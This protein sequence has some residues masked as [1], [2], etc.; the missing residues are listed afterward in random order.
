ML[1]DDFPMML[2][3]ESGLSEQYPPV[4]VAFGMFPQVD[5]A[6]SDA[7]GHDVYVEKEYVRILI[8]GDKTSDVLQPSNDTYR[9]RFPK[10]YEAFKARTNGGSGVSGMPIEQWAPVSRSVAMT[11][12]AAHIPTVETL[13][14]VHEGLI[15]RLPIAA[16]RELREKA[17][18]WLAQARD[19]AE[20]ARK[21]AEN[22]ALRDQIAAMEARMAAMEEEAT[23]KRGR[24]APAEAEAA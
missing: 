7:A 21:A 20:T 6:K 13:A 3:R 24:R 4:A 23:K 9:R 18:A 8:P 2:E 14:E 12:R 11:L 17:R 15:D 1:N 19:G 10:A 22:K 16:P 5:K